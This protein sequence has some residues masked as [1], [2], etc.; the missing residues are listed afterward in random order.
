[1]VCEHHPCP[2]PGEQLPSNL[3]PR[4][5]SKQ[6]RRSER[7]K[8]VA[9]ASNRLREFVLRTASHNARSLRRPETIELTLSYMRKQ[10]LDVLASQETWREGFSIED[11]KG[12]IIINNN[13]DDA[14][15]RGVGIILAPRLIK[16]WD[17]TQRATL[18]PSD[19]VLAIRVKLVDGEGK[20]IYFCF[21]S[22]YRPISS[23]SEAEQQEFND[24]WEAAMTFA[25]DNDTLIVFTDANAS[26]GI[27][28]RGSGDH[29]GTV[30][31]LGITHRNSA[32]ED[33]LQLMRTNELCSVTSFRQQGPTEVQLRAR[34]KR[35]NKARRG[36]RR[37]RA[38]RWKR[39]QAQREKQLC[40][41][42]RPAKPTRSQRRARAAE[43]E[44][45][46]QRRRDERFASWTHPGSK[47]HF[48]IDYVMTRQRDLRRTRGAR[49]TR[50]SI[51][52]DHRLL[53]CDFAMAKSLARVRRAPAKV[54]IDRARL[55]EEETRDAFID[56]VDADIKACAGKVTFEVLDTILVKQAERQL[57][58]SGRRRLSW[59]MGAEADITAAQR[60]RDEAWARWTAVP[61]G[62]AR[63]SALHRELQVAR[64][65]VKVEVKRARDAWLEK[66]LKRIET[67]KS[68]GAMLDPC[69]AW[70]AMKELAAGMD[71]TRPPRNVPVRGEHGLASNDSEQVQAFAAHF[72]KLFNRPSTYDK[73]VLD[74]LEQRQIMWAIGDK[75]AIDEVVTFLRRAANGKAASLSGAIGEYY[76]AISFDRG[77]AQVVTDLVGEFWD[78]GNAP[79]SWTVG[80]LKEIGK[81]GKDLSKCGNYRGVCLIEVAQKATSAL[82]ATRLQIL[83]AAC[84]FGSQAGFTVGR[85]CP[86]SSFSLKCILHQLRQMGQET[87]VVFIDLVKAF[88]SV[89]REAMCDI[90][91][92]YGAPPKLV[93]VV[94][95]M[96]RQTRMK[97]FSGEEEFEFESKIGVLQG[98]AASPVIFLFV[99]AAWFETMKWPTA[100]I[101]VRS[102]DGANQQP[103]KDIGNRR[104]INDFVTGQAH[105]SRDGRVTSIRDFLYADDAALLWL[106]RKDVA[107]GMRTA[108]AHGK[109]WGLEVHVAPARD[110][111]SKTEFIVVPPADH[112]P[113]FRGHYDRS[114]IKVGEVWITHAA[115]KLRGIIHRGVFKYLGSY[116]CEDLR[117]DLDVDERINGASRAFG[118]FKKQIFKNGALSV[119]AKVRAFTAFVLSTL[120]YQSE[121][122]AL[123][124]DQRRK[125][126]VFFNRC[127]R[128]IA[129]VTKRDQRF[130]RITTGQLAAR[131][132]LRTCDSYLDERCLRWAGHVA[133][134]AHT[135]LPRI[136]MFAWFNGEDNGFDVTNGHRRRAR[137]APIMS[138]GRRLRTML[139]GMEGPSETDLHQRLLAE[140]WVKVAQDRRAWDT[141]VRQYCGIK[142]G[143]A[144]KDEKLLDHIEG[145][146]YDVKFREVGGVPPPTHPCWG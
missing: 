18:R 32:G 70:R 92:R 12:Y 30:G 25:H 129:C 90:L 113:N 79:P 89:D 142:S 55:Q 85:G 35:A 73:T 20:D 51:G 60:A 75:P 34:R 66:A 102:N 24:A 116:I 99:I 53:R 14:R 120:F 33:V 52:S 68:G 135:R 61:A 108:I 41:A 146:P 57:A 47:R 110:K 82:L 83:L 121:C 2:V 48:Q 126:C 44:A 91:G 74:E 130:K 8:R 132:G 4:L 39:V 112:H 78:S 46:R 15:R 106:S 62:S 111:P 145:R 45:T 80:R 5:P 128:V 103:S 131:V 54:R 38:R 40:A 105:N 69:D 140:G 133:R 81:A 98:A 67:V 27:G 114:P 125:V 37:V 137:G 122:W 95:G 7:R 65:R 28:G 77:V 118:Q 88:D 31:P 26:I 36:G 6:N 144:P 13:R 3:A 96:H 50:D 64:K 117:E 17:A 42:P 97:M 139:R 93:G 49:V 100:P 56:A 9:S 16:A 19:R 123:R 134:M 109:R 1:M 23:A 141:M 94:R 86:D 59:F 29:D 43:A 10:R 21:V 115:A 143:Y 58:W 72:E 76:K 127:V 119:G 107:E 104:V 124:K 11:N 136:A 84:D 63:G 22:A 71:E 87:W 138:F 101:L